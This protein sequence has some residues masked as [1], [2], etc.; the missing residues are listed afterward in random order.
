MDKLEEMEKLA[1]EVTPKTIG[2]A[3]ASI[4]HLPAYYQ[5]MF[6]RAAIRHKPEILNTKRMGEWCRTMDYVM[7]ELISYGQGKK[8]GN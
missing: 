5:I 2:E 7:S 1:L 4:A 8:G 6:A 3:L